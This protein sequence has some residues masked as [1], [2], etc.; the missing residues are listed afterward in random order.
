MEE[1]VKVMAR[2]LI[3]LPS[4][5]RKKMELKEGDILKIEVQD[6]KVVLKKE[7]RIYDFK[8]VIGEEKPKLSKSFSEILQEE[9]RKKGGTK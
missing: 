1:I 5:I 7:K 9:L 2:G 6:D 4:D 3:A 8:G